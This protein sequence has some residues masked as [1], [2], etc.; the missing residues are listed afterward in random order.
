MSIASV[1]FSRFIPANAQAWL[2]RNSASRRS[3]LLIA[4]FALLAIVAGL[5]VVNSIDDDITQQLNERRL[6]L[7]QLETLEKAEIWHQRR[8]ETDLAR[9]Q[10]EAHLWEAETDGIAQANF[11]TWIADQAKRA[12]IGP[13]DVHISTNPADANPLKLRQLSA[14]ILS[15]PPRCSSWRT[16]LRPMN[17]C[18]SL[19]DLRFKRRRLRFSRCYSKPIFARPA[20]PRRRSECF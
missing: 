6:R 14:Q 18:L 11:Q 12:G 15:I 5:K 1:Q 8:S 16:R 10:A 13:I 7:A 20:P 9:V 19:S 2:R 4:A 17:G 3:R